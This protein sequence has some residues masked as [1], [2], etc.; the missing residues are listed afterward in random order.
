MSME[1]KLQCF[2]LRSAAVIWGGDRMLPGGGAKKIQG[3]LKTDRSEK[4]LRKE[5]GE[6][7]S[8]SPF[9][10]Q[11]RTKRKERR[12]AR[13]TNFAGIFLGW[14]RQDGTRFF[15]GSG[16]PS[17]TIQAKGNNDLTED[18]KGYSNGLGA[19]RTWSSSKACGEKTW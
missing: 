11:T 3:K 7:Q 5:R 19:Q 18:V 1:D 9:N 12:V 2:T 4:I 10:K 17:V 6:S 16:G 15:G 14:D 8:G 13:K